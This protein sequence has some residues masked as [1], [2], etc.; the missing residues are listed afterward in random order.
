MPDDGPTSSTN[1][2]PLPKFRFA[3]KWAEGDV[4][5]FQEV[6]GLDMESQPIEYRHGSSPQFSA[7]RMPGLKKYSDVTLKRGVFKSNDQFW[8]W[9]NEIKTNTIQ[10]RPV[11]ISLLA[12]GG[13]PVMVWTLAKAWPNKISG[14]DLRATGNPT[15][16]ETIVISHEGL[17]ITN[18]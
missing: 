9:F 8:A 2:W 7:L 12:V 16:V 10:R 5:H 15:A 6:S 4:M 1:A 11:T 14:T 13:A 18:A 17:T 3:V